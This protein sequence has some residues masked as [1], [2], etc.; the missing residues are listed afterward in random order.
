LGIMILRLFYTN[1]NTKIF[2]NTIHLVRKYKNY[3]V[4]STC[5]KVNVYINMCKPKQQTFNYYNMKRIYIE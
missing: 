1:F 4:F 3:I 5:I 2:K